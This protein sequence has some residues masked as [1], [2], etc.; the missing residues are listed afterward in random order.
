MCTHSIGI[1]SGM[2][3]LTPGAVIV[4]VSYDNSNGYLTVL[5]ADGTRYMVLDIGIGY[6]PAGFK[7]ASRAVSY[8]GINPIERDIPDICV[9]KPR[10]SSPLISAER[11]SESRTESSSRSSTDFWIALSSESSTE[12]SME[13]SAESSSLSFIE[14]TADYST[15]SSTATSSEFTSESSESYSE[16]STGITSG[17]SIVSLT[18]SSSKSSLESSTGTSSGSGDNS[19]EL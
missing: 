7:V 18:V 4:N 6:D 19:S 14:T 5:N 16:S 11:S 15:G 17:S 10:I 3:F 12:S 2:T 13:S 9:C 1:K 8:S